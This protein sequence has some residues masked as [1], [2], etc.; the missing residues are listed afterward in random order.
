MRVRFNETLSFIGFVNLFDGG[1]DEYFLEHTSSCFS[2][3]LINPVQFLLINQPN[4]I[5]DMSKTHS[6][7]NRLQESP[8][9]GTLEVLTCSDKFLPGGLEVVEL[10]HDLQ[11]LEEED[12]SLFGW[13][14]LASCMGWWVAGG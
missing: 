2:V 5:K 4:T 10:V 3:D 13:F 12:C 7:V 8:P 14:S 6:S 11:L 9:K 1:I